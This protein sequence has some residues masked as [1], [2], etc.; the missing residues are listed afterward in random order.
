VIQVDLIAEQDSLI[1]LASL[2][3]SEKMKMVEDALKVMDEE[4]NKNKSQQNKPI[5]AVTNKPTNDNNN[6]NSEKGGLYVD[7][8]AAKSSGYNDF[9]KRWGTRKLEDNWR[10]SDKSTA[11]TD[12]NDSTKTEVSEVPS[13]E[14]DYYGEK[15][16]LLAQM[17]SAEDANK[18]NGK[19]AE[20][21]F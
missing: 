1:K 6:P 5:D 12:G 10:R 13:D 9:I 20:A 2:S 15:E 16:K 11:F 21:Y 7:N 8:A 4:F 17:P 14:F 18:M 19:M 3:E